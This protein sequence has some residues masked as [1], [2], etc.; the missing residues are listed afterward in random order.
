[1]KIRILYIFILII[2]LGS[3]IKNH[4]NKE[5]GSNNTA[6]DSIIATGNEGIEKEQW[7]GDYR[8]LL[9]CADCQGIDMLLSLNEDTTYFL[10]M[11]YIGKGEPFVDKGFFEWNSDRTKIVIE[12]EEGKQEF[13]IG[14]AALTM[15]NSKGKIDKGELETSFVLTKIR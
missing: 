4:D 5:K 10:K 2:A 12:S 14:D 7:V 13:L 8:G 1:M 3:C 9:P 11:E 15:L 6:S